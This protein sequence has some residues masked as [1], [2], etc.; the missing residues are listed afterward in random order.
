MSFKTYIKFILSFPK[1]FY[2]NFKVFSL[3]QACKLPILVDY[4]TKLSG[5]HRG[6]IQIDEKIRPFMIKF[7]FQEG[8]LGV[9]QIVTDNYLIFGKTGKAVF[10]G[11]AQFAR[12]ISLRIDS[13][14][15]SFGR[16]FSC[17]KCCFIACNRE[18]TF[19]NDVLIGWHTNIRDMDGHNV[20]LGEKID[21][22]LHNVERPIK[23]GNNVWIA[24][25]V[26]ILK[27][28]E[29]PDGCIVAYRSCVYKKFEQEKCIIGGYP[30]RIVKENILWE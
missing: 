20:W 28:S 19:G 30:A 17:N 2:V 6:C 18:I 22:C 5:L 15:I 7:G 29:I 3:M 24:S 14:T 8:T 4:R 25:Y 11:K 26:D 13:G 10:Y 16:N 9:P 27:G 1:T 21:S 12:G 23:I